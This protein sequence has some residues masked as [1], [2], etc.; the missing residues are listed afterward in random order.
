MDLGELVGKLKDFVDGRG[1]RVGVVDLVG[2]RGKR[3]G[4]FGDPVDRAA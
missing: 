2:G 3:M 1:K 4:K